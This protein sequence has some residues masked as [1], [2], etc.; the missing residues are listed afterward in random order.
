M[1]AGS[2]YSHRFAVTPQVYEG[3]LATFGDR[4][5]LHTDEAFAHAHGF[6]SVVMHGNILNGFLSYFVGELLPLENVII[7][8]QEI[9]FRKPVYLHDLL[10]F[11]ATVTESSEAVRTTVFKYRFRRAAESVA[12][13]RL[14]VGL[15]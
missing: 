3:F 12:T 10:D 9:R 2:T 8:S 6:G 15:L 13:G 4:N 5:S 7:H 14:Q 11:E 1:E